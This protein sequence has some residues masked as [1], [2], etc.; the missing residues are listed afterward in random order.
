MWYIIACIIF[1]IIV[2]SICIII[3]ENNKHLKEKIENNKKL[4][5]SYDKCEFYLKENIE[6]KRII[7]L[8]EDN[9]YSKIETL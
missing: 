4:L 9:K 6:L 3:A 7:A 1:I 8:Y 5:K 2:N